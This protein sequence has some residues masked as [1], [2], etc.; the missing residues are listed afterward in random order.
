[1]D[2]IMDV[3]RATGID[4]GAFRRHYRDGSAEAALKQDL[5]LTARLGIRSL[6]ACLVQRRGKA[7]LLWSFAYEDYVNAIDE[8]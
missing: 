6:P 4:E 3:A 2:V 7:R 1:M 8:L 5:L